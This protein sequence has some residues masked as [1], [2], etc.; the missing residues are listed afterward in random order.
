MLEKRLLRSPFLLGDW[1]CR[2][3]HYLSLL[4]NNTSYF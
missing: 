2:D 4:T 1:L 3:F